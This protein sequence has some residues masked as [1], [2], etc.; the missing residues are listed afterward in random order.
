MR[1]LTGHTFHSRRPP[2]TR[3][4]RWLAAFALLAATGAGAQTDTAEVSFTVDDDDRVRIEVP[5]AAD[6]YHV[7]WYQSDP[8]NA[9]TARAVAIHMGKA[10]KVVLSEPLRVGS[11]GAYRVATH[12]KTAPADSDGDGVDD[13]TELA[14]DASGLRAPLNSASTL[15]KNGKAM[16]ITDGAIGIPDLATFKR[17][18]RLSAYAPFEPHLDGLE[19]VKY[20]ITNADTDDA[21][22]WFQN[23]RHRCCHYQFMSSVVNLGPLF[24]QAHLRGILVYHPH[25][26]APSGAVGTL[27]FEYQPYDKQPFARV[28]RSMELLA[29]NMPFLRNNLVYYP[30]PRAMPLYKKEKALYDNSRVPVYLDADIS[31]AVFQPLNAAVGYGRLGVFHPGQW[32]TF[33]DVV[34]LPRLPNELPTVAGI[35]T[36]ERQTP[37]SHVN[38]RAVQ[39]GVPNA[40]VGNALENETIAPLLGKYVRY[41]VTGGLGASWSLREAT[42]AEVATHHATRRPAATRTP[43]RD[44]TAT[45]YADLDD[46]AFANAGAYGAKA[47]NLAELRDLTLADVEVPDG[48]ALPFYFYDE[49]M[50]HN[51]LY[52]T[53]D[54]LLADEEFQNDIG[55]RDASLTRLRRAIRDGNFTDALRAKIGE[56]QDEFPDTTPIRCRSSTNNEDLPAFNGAGLYDSFTHHPHEGHLEKSI[57]QVF[58]SLW[59][60]QAFEAREFHRVDHKAAAMGVLLH[61]NFS[62]E[63]ANGVAASENVF[64]TFGG[65]ADAYYVNAQLGEELVTN[66]SGHLPE[67]LLLTKD[68]NFTVSVVRRSTLAKDGAPVL[69]DAHIAT[70]HAAL[71]TIDARF[72]TLHAV[73]DDEKFAIE[74]EFKVTASNAVAIKQARPWVY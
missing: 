29:A 51:G 10:G 22:I 9:A 68:A 13:L 71:G 34:I 39:D 16:A 53:V 38:L 58:A 69:S 1:R 8:E 15:D 61:P 49:F 7:L 12:L 17:L 19:Y 40:Y 59:N 43:F 64:I 52:A 47:V 74:I 54:G 48:Y 23:T 65:P 28:A 36:M 2:A 30:M 60:L 44:L 14:R 50:K 24:N 70:L 42:A 33:R 31:Q 37:L 27:R 55:E 25:L 11:E 46:I 35:I 72:R 18:S 45:T 57:K 26:V 66:P 21:R 67:E 32:P 63:K 56:L 20:I 3:R 6:R 4:P 73:A 5:S 62:D 41:E